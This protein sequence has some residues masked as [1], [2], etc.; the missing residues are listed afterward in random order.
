MKKNIITAVV[1]IIV[2]GLLAAG[3][4]FLVGLLTFRR[5][6]EAPEAEAADTAKDPYAF[7]DKPSFSGY[8]ELTQFENWS[9]QY[10]P[11][12]DQLLWFYQK[13]QRQA[14]YNAVL[15]RTVLEIE[16]SETDHK[17]AFA[18]FYN[19]VHIFWHIDQVNQTLSLYQADGQAVFTKDYDAE[20]MHLPEIYLDLV[21]YDGEY[22]RTDADGNLTF[23]FHS[24]PMHPSLSGVTTTAAGYYY[25]EVDGYLHSYSAWVYDDCMK[26]FAYYESPSY[27]QE[28]HGF[29]LNDGNLL[30]QYRIPTVN[31]AQ[32]YDLEISGKKYEL[33]SLIFDVKTQKEREVT[34]DYVLTSGGGQSRADWHYTHKFEQFEDDVINLAYGYQIENKRIDTN[35][36]VVYTISNQGAV[37]ERL[38]DWVPHQGKNLPVAVSSTRYTLS[39]DLA[40]CFFLD[41]SGNILFELHEN[42]IVGEN[43]IYYNN[44]IYDHELNL[45]YDYGEDMTVEMF[46]DKCIL[47][48][49]NATEDVYLFAN[50]ESQIFVEARRASS[51]WCLT[52]ESFFYTVNQGTRNNFDYY[53]VYNDE[54]RQIAY[55]GTKYLVRFEMENGILITRHNDSEYSGQGTERHY[56]FS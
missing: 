32:E 34:L 53:R 46:Y 33:V 8:E 23:A 11:E 15:N 14:I 9:V 45:L 30:V 4:F 31:D 49:S 38:N 24:N 25:R 3:S 10:N 39:N 20:T 7:F 36:L 42:A 50:G 2:A 56:R 6:E 51:L 18:E 26:Q 16:G 40:Q 22:Y 48:R 28:A 54:G 1:F 52:Q 5:S 55:I 37:I 12:D 29:V 17:F 41:E 13:G 44:A 19:G 43:Y 47:L 35:D 27:A 21:L